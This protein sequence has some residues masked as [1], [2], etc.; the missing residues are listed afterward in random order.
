MVLA[1]F[2]LH[3][4][5]VTALNQHDLVFKDLSIVLVISFAPPQ[6]RSLA[7]LLMTRLKTKIAGVGQTSDKKLGNS[8]LAR[9]HC[10]W[11][12]YHSK[13]ISGNLTIVLWNP[14]HTK[15]KDWV[16]CCFAP[17]GRPPLASVLSY[18]PPCPHQHVHPH[19]GNSCRLCCRKAE[20]VWA[21]VLREHRQ[22]QN[23]SGAHGRPLRVRLETAD[24]VISGRWRETAD[25]GILADDPRSSVHATSQVSRRIL[26]AHQVQSGIKDQVRSS[27]HLDGNPTIDRP[28]FVQ[29]CANDPDALLDAAQYVAP[30]CDAVDLNLGCPQKIASAGHYGAFL[31]EDWDTIYKM[32][33]KLH[34]ELSVPVTAKMRVLDT[35][36]KTLAYAR[37]ILSAGASILTVHGRRREQKGHNMGVADWSM[38]RY[39]RDNLPPETVLF[40]NGNIL[41]RNDLQPCLDATGADGIMSAEGNL[42]DPTIFAK[43]PAADWH[44]RE[45]WRGSNGMEGYRIDGVIRRYYDI[46]YRHVLETEPPN[47]SP[48]F[49][50]SDPP[51]PPVT[52][53]STPIEDTHAE[54]PRKK[55]RRNEDPKILSHN[56]K[57][58]QGHLFQLIRPMVNT[59]TD[60]RDALGKCRLGDMPAFE[61]VLALIE[62]ATKRSLIEEAQPSLQ[63]APSEDLTSI[64]SDSH[65]SDLT[66]D[67]PIPN[68][69]PFNPLQKYKRPWFICQPY[70]RPSPDEALRSGALK[71][72]KK[73]VAAASEAA[74]ELEIL[75]VK[76]P[77]DIIDGKMAAGIGI[78][79]VLPSSQD[80]A[81]FQAPVCG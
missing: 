64:I 57:F 36:E 2:H 23:D 14:R 21:S 63:H 47:R 26:R 76:T 79:N 3:K 49:I 40:A 27:P 74:K 80:H 28:L 72:S 17:F 30:Y 31:Q 81:P 10:H 9:H 33:N 37:M 11:K 15:S 45:Y 70:I 65:T 32:I 60:I 12:S 35:R 62:E 68:D 53:V 54:P 1:E 4:H 67:T 5:S 78:E 41:N 48:L 51:S 77:G 13:Q 7:S 50:P 71:P 22:S 73:D 19:D 69:P 24:K 44:S 18:R 34:T 55:R 39:L 52:E 66:S 58:M 61:H 25:A 43:Q 75:D 59:H 20:V 56:I 16:P 46:I 8:R 6:H 29:F 42:S 38:I